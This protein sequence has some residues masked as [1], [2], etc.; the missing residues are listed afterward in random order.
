MR[1]SV[2]RVPHSWIGPDRRRRQCL[3]LLLGSAAGAALSGCAEPVPQL[4]L[5]STVFP[6]YEYA[7]LALELGFIE[8][9]QVRVVEYPSTT[10]ALRALAAGQIEAAQLTLDEVITARSAGIG[11]SVV[12]VLDVSAGR[13][14]VLARQPLTLGELAGKRIALEEGATGA[15]LLDGLL[16]AAKLSADQIRKVPSPLAL[17]AGVFKRD[18]ADVVVT[19]EPW[20]S[21]IEREGGFRLF[22]SR[23]IPN[24]IIDVLAV[25]TESIELH[26][27]AIRKLVGGILKAR[28]H[29][30]TQRAGVE[31]KLAPRLQLEASQVAQAFRGL[32]IPTLADNRRMLEPDGPIVIAA[33]A[34]QEVMLAGGLLSTKRP[35]EALTHLLVDAR[36]LPNGDME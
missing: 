6:T 28:R 17:S 2:P 1:F 3:Q 26:R 19:T 11:L 4:R 23:Q 16:R 22:D 32:S 24:R 20:A 21:Q 8:A 18:E 33:Q 7:F 25:R 35:S 10:Y 15:L 13:D 5:G 36:F 31:A 9:A 34:L 14:A 27:T 29:H 30:L 12:L